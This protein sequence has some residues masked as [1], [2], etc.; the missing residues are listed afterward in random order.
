MGVPQVAACVAQARAGPEPTV[1]ERAADK[2]VGALLGG[3]VHWLV[4]KVVGRRDGGARAVAPRR[5]G[6]G[7]VD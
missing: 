5:R 4:A 2:L 6:A 1:G 7:V 3:L